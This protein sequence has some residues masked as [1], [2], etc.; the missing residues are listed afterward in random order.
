LL[1]FPPFAGD[2][3]EVVFSLVL[4]VDDEVK[5]VTLNLLDYASNVCNEKIE[6]LLNMLPRKKSLKKGK[7]LRILGIYMFNRAVC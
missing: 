2:A 5:M 7:Q 3:L 4:V 1:H 6:M